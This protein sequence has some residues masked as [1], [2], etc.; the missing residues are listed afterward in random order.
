MASLALMV[1]FI[2]LFVLLIGPLCLFVSYISYYIPN[3]LVYLLS[4]VSVFVGVWCL[5]IPILTIN[6]LGIIPILCGYYAVDH[7]RKLAKM[8]G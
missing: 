3:I 4:I 7:R 2:L 6:Y 1:S 8:K 5:F